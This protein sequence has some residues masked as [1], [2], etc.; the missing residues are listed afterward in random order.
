MAWVGRLRPPTQLLPTPLPMVWHSTAQA[1]TALA[2]G[3][4]SVPASCPKLT[5]AMMPCEA[6]GTSIF[7]GSK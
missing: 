1:P 6:A 3:A 7:S 2:Q 5:K 4:S